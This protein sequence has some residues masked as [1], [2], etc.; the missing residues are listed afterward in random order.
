MERPA[1]RQR[2]RC[3]A[4]PGA[5]DDRALERDEIDGSGQRAALPTRLDGEVRAGAARRVA[6]GLRR[7]VRRD[8]DI[9]SA[10]A[11]ER[12]AAGDRLDRDHTRRP[13]AAQELRHEQADH[14]LAQHDGALADSWSGIEQDVHRCVDV[15][16]EG[17]GLGVRPRL[18]ADRQR[19]GDDVVR[20]V[21]V[22]REHQVAH[23]VAVLD[24]KIERP[25]QGRQVERELRRHLTSVHEHLRAMRQRARERAHA[26]VARTDLGGRL[27]AQLHRAGTREP[28]RR[29]RDGGARRRGRHARAP[30]RG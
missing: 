30:R 21:R 23:R 29:R 26:D 16:E 19:R 25:G 18:Q 12:A 15:R 13:G 1:Q 27:V 9:C 8:G 10:G 11:G 4:V 7:V 5:H 14:P 22:V 17:R 6:H 24:R 2:D 28:H 20:L 3:R